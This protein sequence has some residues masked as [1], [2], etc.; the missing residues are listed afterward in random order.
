VSPSETDGRVAEQ[1]STG[2]WHSLRIPFTESPNFAFLLP[3]EHGR[4]R[5]NDYITRAEVVTIFFRMITDDNRT[6]NWTQQNQFSDVQLNDWFNNAISTVANMRLIHGMPDGMFAPNRWITRAEFAA[7]VSRLLDNSTTSQE[8]LFTDVGDHWARHYINQIGSI[9]WVSGM[10]NG[11]FEP[12][13]QLTR[14][15][16]AAIISRIL[17]RHPQS[18]DD[19]LKDMTTSVD[20]ADKNAWY[21]LYIQEATNSN[22]SVKKSDG[23]YVSWTELVESPDWKA[24]ERPD[25]TPNSHNMP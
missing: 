24:L 3:D 18:E 7:V 15:E 23:I 13:R 17:D 22:I 6:E 9:G 8:D 11:S 10:G 4:I 1:Q 2:R 5:P 12:D 25:S 21:Y 16:A 19:L 20:N 14:A